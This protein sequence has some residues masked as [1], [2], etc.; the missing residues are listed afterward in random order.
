MALTTPNMGLISWDLLS[1]PYS[2]T[3]L[4]ANFNTLDSHDHTPGSGLIITTPAIE[5]LAVTTEKLA[6]SSVRTVKIADDNVTKAKMDRIYVHPLGSI[7]PWWRPNSFSAI[8]VGWVVA[9]GQ[10]L[11]SLEHDFAG[12]GS[13]TLPDLRNK[14]LLGADTEATGTSTSES[15]AISQAG[16]SHQINISHNHTINPHTHTVPEHNHTVNAHSH[17]V[18]GHSH[19]LQS[20]KHVHFHP[21]VNRV[22]TSNVNLF[23]E[24]RLQNNFQLDGTV[25]SGG[26]SSV[27]YGHSPDVY[28]SG[29]IG[30]KT[31]FA[32]MSNASYTRPYSMIAIDRLQV[33]RAAYPG[34]YGI[35]ASTQSY[36]RWLTYSSEPVNSEG[37][38]ITSTGST[39]VEALSSSPLTNDAALTSNPTT[40]TANPGGSTALDIRPNFVGVLY[41]MKV[42]SNV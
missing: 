10:T 24:G 25:I 3:Q 16:G 41:L 32:G 22:P 26:S 30:T 34:L 36:A 23:D 35:T 17:T 11:T 14:F 37:K 7:M 15:P 8:P 29:S 21:I 12:G 39:S 1:D 9:K 42:K 4:A 18:P 40:A 2:H 13:I 5:D 19:N 28:Y 27:H 20:H 33:D 31:V 6:D 38:A